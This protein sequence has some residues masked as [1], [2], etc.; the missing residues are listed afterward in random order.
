MLLTILGVIP[1]EAAIGSPRAIGI[2]S[3][4]CDGGRKFGGNKR[5]NLKC[6]FQNRQLLI[7]M[8]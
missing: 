2:G 7:S 5:P 3:I 4:K 8:I 6:I 1:I